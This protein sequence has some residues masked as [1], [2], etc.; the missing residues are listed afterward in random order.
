M[1]QCIERVVA[2]K[3]SNKAVLKELCPCQG[4]ISSVTP[5]VLDFAGAIGGSGDREGGCVF[6]WGVPLGDLDARTANPPQ[7]QPA[8]HLQWRHSGHTLPRAAPR[9]P[10]CLVSGTCL[11]LIVA[12]CSGIACANRFGA[13]AQNM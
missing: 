11:I 8:C 5:Q 13:Q 2:E 7:P 1:C 12:S 3:E 4:S 9:C 10:S 6:L